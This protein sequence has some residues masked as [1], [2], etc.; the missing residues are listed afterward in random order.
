VVGRSL[1]VSPSLIVGSSLF[2]SPFLIV[3]PSLLVGPSL[4][5]G[6]PSIFCPALI[7]VAA[8]ISGLARRACL[9][10]RSRWSWC[11]A[12]GASSDR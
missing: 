5:V 8:R 9:S 6:S 2:V 12:R 3:G 7:G 4:F 11:L 1:L 10:L